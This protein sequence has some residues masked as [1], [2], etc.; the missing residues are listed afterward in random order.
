MLKFISITIFCFYINSCGDSEQKIKKDFNSLQIETKNN[1]ENNKEIFNKI[2]SCFAFKYI[3]YI[4]FKTDGD[5]N[6]QYKVKDTAQWGEVNSDTHEWGK[7]VANIDSK[8][9]KPLLDYEGLS[10]EFLLSIKKELN[11]IN[12]NSISMMDGYDV[13]KGFD[14]KAFEI[15]YLKEVNELYFLYRIFDRPIDSIYNSRYPF[16]SRG[17]IG[18]VLDT[19]IIYYYK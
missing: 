14:Y 13:I 17:N 15:K 5:V 18:G 2:K 16:Q 4:E 19:D 9:I 7:I 3:K 10:K 12:A 11:T 1:Y 6:I 8:E